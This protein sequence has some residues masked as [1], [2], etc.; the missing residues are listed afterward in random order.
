[1]GRPHKSFTASWY[2]V[3][4]PRHWLHTAREIGDALASPGTNNRKIS[5][6]RSP[7]LATTNRGG[8]ASNAGRGAPARTP[9]TCRQRR[10]LMAK[11]LIGQ[12]EGSIY[13]TR[14]SCSWRRSKPEP[15]AGRLRDAFPAVGCP[16]RGGPGAPMER[17]RPRRRHGGGLPL[18]AG[19]GRH[20]DAQE[21]SRPGVADEGGP[22]A[23]NTSVWRSRAPCSVLDV[24]LVQPIACR[25]VPKWSPGCCS[26]AEAF[27]LLTSGHPCGRK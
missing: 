15:P 25:V 1:M 5:D 16:H 17:G 8:D 13:P 2:A 12:Y 4:A 14:P 22:S 18:R 11:I 20:Q 7:A 9:T 24:R 3:A 6:R 21:P 10:E 19:Q 27:D 26:Q 23:P